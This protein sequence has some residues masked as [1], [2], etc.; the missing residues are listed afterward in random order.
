MRFNLIDWLAF[1]LVIVGAVNWGLVGI[2]GLDLVMLLFGSLPPLPNIVYA[3]VGLA[4][5][6]L[7]AA[8]AMR[9]TS[10][11]MERA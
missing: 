5:L 1:V 4:G 3:V 9:A 7:A 6:Y 2:A 11:S 10:R 8:L